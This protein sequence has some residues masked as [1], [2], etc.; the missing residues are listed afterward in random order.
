LNSES[1]A[2]NRMGGRGCGMAGGKAKVSQVCSSRSAKWGRVWLR[3]PPHRCDFWSPWLQ[4]QSHFNKK[5]HKQKK[6]QRGGVCVCGEDP[7]VW[8]LILEVPGVGGED[9]EKV[10]VGWVLS[11]RCSGMGVAV[12]PLWAQFTLATMLP[13]TGCPNNHQAGK[14]GAG[15]CGQLSRWVL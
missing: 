1:P 6:P 5:S 10:W 14:P 3:L 13:V 2:C 15:R 12:G 4:G 7:W 11:G 9:R 8:Q